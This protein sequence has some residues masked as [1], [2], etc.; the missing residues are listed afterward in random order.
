MFYLVFAVLMAAA[1]IAVL[2]LRHRPSNDPAK[3]VN[4]FKRAIKALE[5]DAPVRKAGAGRT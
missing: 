4:S 3:S 1:I 2:A 5:P